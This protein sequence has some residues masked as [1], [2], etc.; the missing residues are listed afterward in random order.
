MQHCGRR[1]DVAPR[2]PAVGT[3]FFLLALCFNSLP[4]AATL[5]YRHARS[6]RAGAVL[7]MQV[8]PSLGMGPQTMHPG[9]G[10]RPVVLARHCELVLHQCRRLARQNTLCSVRLGRI[11]QHGCPG[12][13]GPMAASMR[14][15][16]YMSEWTRHIIWISPD[17]D[18][19]PIHAACAASTDC[20]NSSALA[21]LVVSRCGWGRA[22]G[23][24]GGR[25]MHR[26]RRKLH[27]GTKDCIPQY[28]QG[29][30]S[31]IQ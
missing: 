10:C 24:P 19:A 8:Q 6:A 11:T 12:A 30:D 26:N 3:R 23:A 1:P 27:T 31:A 29:E 25:A 9:P 4:T 14:D 22:Q 21:R 7:V 17:R 5:C 15:S 28:S 18:H 20:S 16:R 13:G 2:P